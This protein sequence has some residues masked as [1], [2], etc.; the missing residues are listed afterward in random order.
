MIT[1]AIILG[2]V[3]GTNR[4][5][6]RIPYFE[7]AGDSQSI[8]EATL[9]TPPSLSEEYKQEDVVL[10]GFEDHKIEEVVIIGKLY[11]LDG[12]EPRGFANLQDLSI[13]NSANLPLNTVI[14]GIKW[15]EFIDLLRK[16]Y[17]F[18]DIP[19]APEDNGSYALNCEV[20]SSGKIY[21]W[22]PKLNYPQPG[23]ANGNY[24]LKCVV[25]NGTKVYSWVVEE[26]PVLTPVTYEEALEILEGDE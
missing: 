20:T 11:L 23:D 24:Y 4:Y 26:S 16:S 13:L 8:F 18:A 7:V 19:T 5:Y 9:C 6:V 2:K 25:N 12:N 15:Q 22:G 14:G 21:S 17:T 3:V 10:V 1:K